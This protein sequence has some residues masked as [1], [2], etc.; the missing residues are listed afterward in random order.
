MNEDNKTN[1]PLHE[2]TLEVSKALIAANI[3]AQLT[4]PKTHTPGERAEIAMQVNAAMLEAFSS[5]QS[6]V[7]LRDLKETVEMAMDLL[8]G[9]ACAQVEGKDYP[10]FRATVNTQQMPRKFDYSTDERW[11]ELDTEKKAREALLKTLKEPMKVLDEKTGVLNT[12]TPPTVSGGGETLR[13]S[14]PKG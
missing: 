3:T 10:V 6:Y 11:V 12:A 1:R 14:F 2:E 4:Q 5:L 7:L 9:A 8:K 13:I